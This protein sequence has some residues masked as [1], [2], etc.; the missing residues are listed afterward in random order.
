MYFKA[1]AG[2]FAKW[3]FPHRAAALCVFCAAS[4]GVFAQT[5]ANQAPLA[6]QTAQQIPSSKWASL[7]AAQ[8]RALGPL[9]Q[10]WGTLSEGQRRKWIAI[11]K[12][13]P[14]LSA[15]DQEKMHSRMVEWAALTPKDRELARLNFAQTK[16]VS[17]TDRAADWEAYQA[18]SPE[19]KKKLA[20]AA[21]TKPVGAAVAP[22]PAAR[23][24]LAAVPVTRH[25]P[26]EQRNA[27]KSVQNPAPPA[28]K[29]ESGSSGP[30][31]D[32]LAAPIAQPKS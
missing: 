7:D 31:T 3:T 14:S 1:I 11:A 6:A 26:E 12:N 5:A 13:Y 30:V 15:V 18:L 19:E 2:S 23:D 25:T 21:V 29:P 17:K 22:K 28:P 10:S 27:L 32:P 24:K 4:G 9:A 20:S 16:G 8:Q